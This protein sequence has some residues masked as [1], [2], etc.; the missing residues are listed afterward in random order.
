M[1]ELTQEE[2]IY[3]ILN[4]QGYVDNFYCIDNKITIRLG[5]V[6]NKLKKSGKIELD[7]DKSGFI[8]GT[9]NYCYVL[10]VKETLF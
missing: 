7:E 2:K 9:K 6:I 5:A 8:Q 1:K 4:N 3:N 10:K